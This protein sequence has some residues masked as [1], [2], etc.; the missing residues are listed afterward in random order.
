M[1][2]LIADRISDNAMSD[3]QLA[4]VQ[5]ILMSDV[6]ALGR[7]EARYDVNDE[8]EAGTQLREDGEAV[9]ALLAIVVYELRQ[10]R[11]DRRVLDN[12]RKES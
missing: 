5:S 12:M 8:T 10:R 9:E 11:I 4:R 7:A 1:T 6:S 3:D 2:R